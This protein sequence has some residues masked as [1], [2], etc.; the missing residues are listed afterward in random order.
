MKRYGRNKTMKYNKNAN[1]ESDQFKHEI[2]TGKCQV[3]S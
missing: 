1:T 3:K 2:K